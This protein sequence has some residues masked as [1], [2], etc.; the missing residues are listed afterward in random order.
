MWRAR[1]EIRYDLYEKRKI[2]ENER[3]PKKYMVKMEGANE[4]VP[5]N[6]CNTRLVALHAM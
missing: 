6:S 5:E 4:I 2:E 3:E 1:N